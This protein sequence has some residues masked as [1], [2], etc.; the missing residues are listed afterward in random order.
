MDR[1]TSNGLVWW[2][3]ADLEMRDAI[4]GHVL[5]GV[6]RALTA[7]NPS[8][9]VIRVDTP[10]LMP[11]PWASNPTLPYYTVPGFALR[12]ESTKGTYWV[13][14]HVQH[15]LPVCLYQINK[16]FRDEKSDSL[17]ISALRFRE[18][19]QMEFQLFYAEG[20][21]ADY[22]QSFVEKLM[23]PWPLSVVPLDAS[24]WPPYSLRTTDLQMEGIE[25][26]SLSTRNDF[27]TPVFEMSFGIDR[28]TSILRRNAAKVAPEL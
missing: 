27:K 16:S 5:G 7:I 20:T 3:E 6:R 10:C 24:D 4:C 21:K 23:L 13:Q 11:Q 14:E 28:I 25:I 8:I 26:A 2:D 22:H 17:R 19:N 9:R 18:F 12:A 1:Y 15:K